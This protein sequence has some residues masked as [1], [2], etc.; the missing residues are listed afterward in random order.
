MSIL[1]SIT[2][3]A[4]AIGMILA[5]TIPSIIQARRWRQE[6]NDSSQVRKAE[7]DNIEAQAAEALVGAAG[8][9]VENALSSQI[10][11]TQDRNE[12]REE[13]DKLKKAQAEQDET[14]K[15]IIEGLRQDHAAQLRKVRSDYE[16][17]FSALHRQIE[18]LV[19]RN[20]EL[21]AQNAGLRRR[22]SEA[23]SKISELEKEKK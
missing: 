16:A 14:N 17:E 6:R 20:Q 21:E 4:T 13:L 23:E 10:Q 1:E 7:T 8:R 11:A 3:I 2:S 5:A 19:L 22:L 18:G 9:L 12:L 15:R